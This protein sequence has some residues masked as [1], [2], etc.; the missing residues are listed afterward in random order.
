MMGAVSTWIH[1]TRERSG[2]A[3]LEAGTHPIEV[4]FFQ[5]AGGVSLGLAIDGPGFEKQEVP[6]RLLLHEERR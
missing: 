4:H 1:G 6:G 2:Y 3:A 5:G